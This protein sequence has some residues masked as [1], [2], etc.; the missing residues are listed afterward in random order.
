MSGLYRN[1]IL[2]GFYPDPSVCRVGDDYYLVN[3][4]Y[5]VQAGDPVLVGQ[6][7]VEDLAQCGEG[8]D[9]TD[10]VGV[11]HHP[12]PRQVVPTEP[13]HPSERDRVRG[14]EPRPLGHTRR[15]R[16]GPDRDTASRRGAAPVGQPDLEPA[17][18][19]ATGTYSRVGRSVLGSRLPWEVIQL[20][21]RGLPNHSRKRALRFRPCS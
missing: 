18:R 1:P 8:L 15:R 3:S 7:T 19:P 5:P 21:N 9:H 4:T 11:G 2:P 13:L 14:V 16:Q 6:R 17:P 20:A 10:P 12:L